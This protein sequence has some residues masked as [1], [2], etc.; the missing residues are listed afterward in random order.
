MSQYV[1]S[2]QAKRYIGKSSFP[3]ICRLIKI[4]LQLLN[5]LWFVEIFLVLHYGTVCKLSNRFHRNLP[6]SSWLALT[7]RSEFK[8]LSLT[9]RFVYTVKRRYVYLQIDRFFDVVGFSSQKFKDLN[10]YPPSY[11]ERMKSALWTF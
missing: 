2:W 10:Q 7:I 8:L 4:S 9:N 5:T 1:A 6:S 11:V 3:L